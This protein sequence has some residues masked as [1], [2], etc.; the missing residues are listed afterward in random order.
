MI[1]PHEQL[2][3]TKFVKKGGDI[4]IMEGSNPEL[5]IAELK[6]RHTIFQTDFRICKYCD[7]LHLNY[8]FMPVIVDVDNKITYYQL[9]NYLK[10]CPHPHNEFFCFPQKD[11]NLLYVREQL[12]SFK[13]KDKFS[14]IIIRDVSFYHNTATEQQLAVGE[15]MRVP[16]AQLNTPESVEAAKIQ[17]INFQQDPNFKLRN[18]EK[19]TEFLVENYSNPENELKMKYAKPEY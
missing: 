4:I 13:L 11:L 10:E 9:L 7:D 2:N 6:F 5:I 17:V 15:S 18:V 8:T 14:H 3:L 16:L 1:C 12:D 19:A